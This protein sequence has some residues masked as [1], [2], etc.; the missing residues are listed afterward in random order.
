MGRER[1]KKLLTVSTKT[2]NQRCAGAATV[3][4]IYEQERIMITLADVKNGAELPAPLYVDKPF[5]IINKD[6]VVLDA[7][8][9][10]HI[11]ALTEYYDHCEVDIRRHDS[12][13]ND[14]QKIKQPA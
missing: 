9:Y 2:A 8:S 5:V 10:A 3:P 12:Y 11:S 13:L 7:G 1:L 14:N 4:A 6:G